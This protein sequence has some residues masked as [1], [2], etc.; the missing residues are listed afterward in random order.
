MI[1][2]SSEVINTP[3]LLL[4][5]SRGSGEV[6]KQVD[7]FVAGQSCPYIIFFTCLFTRSIVFLITKTHKKINN[8]FS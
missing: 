7:A 4:L 1:L 3:S 5:I 8:L 2:K 6:F